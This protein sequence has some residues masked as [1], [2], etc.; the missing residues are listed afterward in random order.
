MRY[1]GQFMRFP[2]KPKSKRRIFAVRLI[3][4]NKSKSVGLIPQ[5][6]ESP[7]FFIY[8]TFAMFNTNILF[9]QTPKTVHVAFWTVHVEI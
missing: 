3:L 6:V 4:K 9:S 5:W 8:K 7:R 1:F 2:V